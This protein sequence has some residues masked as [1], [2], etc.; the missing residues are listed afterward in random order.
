MTDLNRGLQF[1]SAKLFCAIRVLLE[2]EALPRVFQNRVNRMQCR[3]VILTL[4]LTFFFCLPVYL[5]SRPNGGEIELRR[6]GGSFPGE[7]SCATS[8]C[9]G[10]PPNIGPG[11]VSITVNSL[12]LNQYSY[13]PGETVPV[14]VTISDPGQRRWGFQLTAR[15][16]DGCSQAGTFAA[17]PAESLVLIRQDTSAVGGCPQA[18]IQFPVHLFPKSGAG[19]Q[20]YTVNWTAPASNIGSIVFAA[21]GNAANGDNMNTGD[22]IYTTEGTVEAGGGGGGLNPSISSGGVVLA[23]LLPTVTSISVNSI[24]SVYGENMAADGTFRLVKSGD[25]I[26]DRLP[27]E[28]AGVCVEVD[29]TRSPLFFVS[30]LQLNVQSPTLAAMGPVSVVVITGCGTVSESRS[31]PEFVTMEAFTPAFFVKNFLDAGGKNPIAALH[32]D[33]V[34][35]VRDPSEVPGA[36]AA[37]PGEFISLFAT[38]FG[39]TNPPFSAGEVPALEAPPGIAGLTNPVSVTI[40]GLPVPDKDVFYAG[41]APCCAGLYQLVVKVPDS[42]PDGNLPVIATVAGVSTPDGPYVTVERQ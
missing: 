34:N 20:S 12:P 33:G 2:E 22:L 3:R 11:Q 23:N 18:T 5:L 26:D 25:L 32:E 31:D 42:A 6:T 4:V 14:V 30:P 29:G 9:H 8:D 40:G 19:G 27:T 1:G 21:A 13:T 7:S 37:A 16:P 15:T 38:G 28:L 10:G 17:S 41:V 24:I 35:E 39:P 36:T